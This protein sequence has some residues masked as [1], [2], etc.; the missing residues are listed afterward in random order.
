MGL[1]TKQRKSKIL[2]EAGSLTASKA[3]IA[4]KEEL[5]ILEIIAR[6]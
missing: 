2:P 6:D 3:A 1:T 5:R 4:S